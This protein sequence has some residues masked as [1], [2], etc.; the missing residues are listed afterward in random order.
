MSGC[1][2]EMGMADPRE[3][4]TRAELTR[5]LRELFD[6]SPLSYD[7]MVA[8]LGH[9]VS[10]STLHDMVTGKR[11]PQSETVRLFIKVCRRDDGQ[12]WV[13]ARNR[14]AAADVTLRR[15]RTPPA[16][17]VRAGEPVPRAAGSFQDREAAA[18]LRDAVE[19]DGT[20]VLT[21]VLAGMGG[22]GKTQLAAAYARQAWSEGLGLLAWVNASS[23]D[24]IVAAYTDA[25]L[26]LE[27]AGADK[28]DPE[29]SAREFLS[30]AEIVTD[31]WWLV[32]LDDVQRAGDLSGLWPPAAE[33]AAAGQVL[34]TTRL[35]EAALAGPDRRTVEV[36]VF[37]IAEAR[38]YLQAKLGDKAPEEQA[39]ALASAL[40]MLPLALAQATAYI[41]NLDITIS[42]YL[43][44]LAERLLRD[45]VPEPG[46]LTD[47]HQRIITATWELSISQADQARP[48]GLARPLLELASVLDPAGTPQQVLA[49][50][51]AFAYLSAALT[52]AAA[53]PAPTVDE[54]MVDEALRVLHRY[55][56]IDHDRAARYREVR[57]HQLIQR[58]TRENLTPRPGQETS[59]LAVL[60][61]AAA[62]TLISVWP[63]TERDDLGRVLRD[64]TAALQQAA[65][66]ALWNPGDG[67]H[68]V[69]FRS[70]DTLGETGQV[71][72]AR[73][74]YTALYQAALRRLGPDHPDTLATRG[75]LAG[76]RARV[77][78]TAG[79]VAVFEELLTDLLRVLGPE[80]PDTLTTRGNLAWL[81][82]K[83]GDTA[84]EAAGAEELF[85]DRLR[86]LGPEHPDTLIAR[87]NLA[88]LRGEAGD[89]AGAAAAFDELLGDLLRVS[90]PD[91]PYT[92]IARG[93]LAHWWGEAGDAAAAAAATEELLTDQ[94]RVLG[95]DHPDTLTT[96]NNLAHW[97]GEA[98]DAA[99]AAAAAEE[100]LTDQLRVLGPNHPDILNTGNNLARWRGEAGDAAGAAA[101]FDELLGDLL[102]VVG[103]DHPNTLTTRNNLAHWRG[104]AGDAA[105][106]AAAFDELLGDLLRVL[107]PDHPNTL[108]TRNSLAHWRNQAGLG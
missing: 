48:A 105:G 28:E 30:W 100:L 108:A 23:R 29:R 5:A 63:Q 91:H 43:D 40:G 44:L 62:D 82:G 76:W 45:V 16:R 75:Q 17:Q 52:P 36:P 39:D 85:R 68:P 73:D 101:A 1:P 33:S 92:L 12:A 27:L 74:A 106:A 9:Q 35:R 78:D 72:A 21:Q 102:R 70:A 54:E 8:K 38:A 96:R 81:R 99:G 87:G 4:R 42:R 67:G 88:R 103:P 22:V 79:A 93:N 2:E 77:G 18:R 24:A 46:N 32:V 90:G 7:A 49:G 64:C 56:L 20:V 84:G 69:L 25:A 55:S 51:P 86:L 34:V 61:R 94:L 95:P 107:G 83:A 26:K 66:Q 97:R 58:A 80:H 71:A 10:K 65:G 47:D 50:P 31:R 11:F 57:V 89:A 98:G 14:V 53:G 41:D 37:T 60:A 3:I 13:D 6:Q 19:Q 15:P 59:P 104:E